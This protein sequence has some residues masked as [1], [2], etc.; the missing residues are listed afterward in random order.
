MAAR[1]VSG[2]TS[3]R[4]KSKSIQHCQ[5]KLHIPRRNG[6]VFAS[7][8]KRVLHAKGVACGPETNALSGGAV[9]QVG[10]EMVV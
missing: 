2:D 4:F 5:C 8:P 7:T 9:A 10:D 3:T 1:M 6:S